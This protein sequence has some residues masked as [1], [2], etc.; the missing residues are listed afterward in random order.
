[1]RYKKIKNKSSLLGNI[2]CREMLLMLLIKLYF[3]YKLKW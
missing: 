2:Y 3:I 1:M